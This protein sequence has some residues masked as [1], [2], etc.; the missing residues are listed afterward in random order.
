MLCLQGG[1]GG[2]L[3]PKSWSVCPRRSSLQKPAADRGLSGGPPQHPQPEAHRHPPSGLAGLCR[4]V[5]SPLVMGRRF[6]WLSCFL[7]LPQKMLGHGGLWWLARVPGSGRSWVWHGHFLLSLMTCSWAIFLCLWLGGA[8]SRVK[9]K[10]PS[11]HQTSSSPGQAMGEASVLWPLPAVCP[12]PL[13]SP[14]LRHT[15]HCCRLHGSRP[16]RLSG[17]LWGGTGLCTQEARG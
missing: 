16:L 13:V 9:G 17:G 7:S 11:R 6:P 2:P 5:P 4:C 8:G 1:L 14:V 10:C 3:S 12:E 15:L